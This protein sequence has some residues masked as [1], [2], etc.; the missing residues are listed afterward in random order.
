M[1]FGLELV[2]TPKAERLALFNSRLI[3]AG[4]HARSHTEPIGTSQ[5]KAEKLSNPAVAPIDSTLVTVGHR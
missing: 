4:K 1:A 5:A 3:A 2:P